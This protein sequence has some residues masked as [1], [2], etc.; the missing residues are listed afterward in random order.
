MFCGI[1]GIAVIVA[2]GDPKMSEVKAMSLKAVKKVSIIGSGLMGAQIA[3]IMA[4]VGGYPVVMWDMN[5]ELLAKGFEAIASSLKRFFVDKGKMSQEEAEQVMYRIKGTTEMA[6]AANANFIVEAV[7]EN[8]NIKQKVF[9]QLDEAAPANAYLASN[10]SYLNI[11]DLAGATSRPDKVIGMH[12]FNPV[13]VMTLVEVVRG[14]LSSDETT[15]LTCDLARKLGKEPI[16]C[17]D[18]S[19]GFLANRAYRA[20]R[21]EALQMVWERVATPQDIDKALKLGYNLPKGPL[22]LTD[23]TGGWGI[24]VASEADSVRELGPEK[25][26]VHPLIRMMVRAGYTGG[27]D[28]KGIY[29]FWDEILSKW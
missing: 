1:E 15:Q 19:Y 6:E 27:R 21:N 14:T 29:A 12:F 2:Q 9:R 17:R 11:T 23:M 5:E 28:K 16:V 10:T 25:G 20:M 13:A 24:A 18:F 22:E 8:M 4:R 26:Y 7:P 3:E